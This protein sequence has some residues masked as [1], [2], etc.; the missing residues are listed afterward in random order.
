ME[1][2]RSYVTDENFTVLTE[3]SEELPGAF[4]VRLMPHCGME[5]AGCFVELVMSYLD[6]DST[7]MAYE[8]LL[9]TAVG[10][11]NEQLEKLQDAI[12]VL[13]EEKQSNSDVVTEIHDFLGREN[14]STKRV[15]KE[16]NAEEEKQKQRQQDEELKQLQLKALSNRREYEK[17]QKREF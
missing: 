16:Q 12:A 17:S 4:Q 15:I 2:I 1:V 10:L 9:E 13:R 5:T 6:T 14:S 11:T 3:P 7:E 8:V